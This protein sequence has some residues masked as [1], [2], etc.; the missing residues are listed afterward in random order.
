MSDLSNHARRIIDRLADVGP[1]HADL[2]VC[3]VIEGLVAVQKACS[4]AVRESLD[5]AEPHSFGD[6]DYTRTIRAPLSAFPGRAKRGVAETHRRF[7]EALEASERAGG[8]FDRLAEPP[9]TEDEA[10]GIMG[11]SSDDA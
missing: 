10:R 9:F 2:R 1:G 4:Q 11:L 6:S 8:I 3:V 5:A 7:A